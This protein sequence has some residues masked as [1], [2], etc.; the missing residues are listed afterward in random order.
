VIFETDSIEHAAPG[1]ISRVG[2]ICI[3]NVATIDSLIK[4]HLSESLRDLTTDDFV[5]GLTSHLTSALKKILTPKRQYSCVVN[6]SDLTVTTACCNNISQLFKQH[7]IILKEKE[8]K[9]FKKIIDR[10]TIWAV[11]WGLGSFISQE[12]SARFETIVCDVFKMDNLPSGNV[13]SY[14]LSSAFEWVPW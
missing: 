3:D 5:R 14:S 11:V 6:I 2:K 8:S 1:L 13:F 4:Y 9:D 10:L 12:S 7:D